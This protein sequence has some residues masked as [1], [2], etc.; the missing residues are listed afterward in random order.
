MNICY[1][2]ES[3]T[4]EVPGTSSHFVLAGLSIPVDRWRSTD[5]QITAVLRPY[6]LGDAELHT[7]WLVRPYVEQSQ[8]PNFVQLDYPSRKS[9]VDR[10]RAQTLLNLQR[11]R[12]KKQYRQTKKNYAHTL[13]YTHL[14]LD[15]RRRLISD[16]AN[17]IAGWNFATLFAECIDKIHFDPVRTHRSVGEQGF[18]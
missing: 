4:P 10:A 15:E 5:S 18:V 1:I 2:D 17:V 8:I 13:A 9:A 16:I 7:A 6:D 11:Q 14:T 12:Q 3:G